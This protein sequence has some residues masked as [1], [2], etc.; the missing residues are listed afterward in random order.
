MNPAIEVFQT[1]STEEIAAYLV[2]MYLEYDTPS[3]KLGGYI[4]DCEAYLGPED[5][6]AHSHGMKKTP[7]LKAM[8]DHPGT[9][10]L[11]EPIS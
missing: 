4:V 2:G 5:E 6:A 10:Y 8:Y 7:R 1:K 9:I 3:G 11:Y